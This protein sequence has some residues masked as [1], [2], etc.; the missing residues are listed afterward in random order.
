FEVRYPLL[1]DGDGWVHDPRVRVP[2]LLQ[3]EVRPS[4]FGVLEHVAGGLEDRHCASS[5]VRVGP[6]AG[7]E[8]PGLESERPR[9]LGYPVVGGHPRPPRKRRMI[10]ICRASSSRK[11][12][13]PYGASMT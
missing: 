9:R 11:Q 13:W 4:R 2:V 7:M 1:E 10:G 5:G 3:V 8:L 6:L 12:S